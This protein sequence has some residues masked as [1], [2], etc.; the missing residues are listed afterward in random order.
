MIV[1]KCD[2]CNVWENSKEK[3]FT[4]IKL[5]IYISVNH[6]CDNEFHLCK[7]CTSQFD[8]FIKQKFRWEV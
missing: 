3:Q 5:R 6:A 4:E 1:K 7:F 8:K 2:R